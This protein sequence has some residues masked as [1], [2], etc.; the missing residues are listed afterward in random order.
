MIM[1]KCIWSPVG[2][3]VGPL[4]MNTFINDQAL[5]GMEDALAR[6]PN[7]NHLTCW[8]KELTQ[9]DRIH[10]LIMSYVVRNESYAVVRPDATVTIVRDNTIDDKF[11][12]KALP[13]EQYIRINDLHVGE[14][15]LPA[16][17]FAAWASEATWCGA[18]DCYS[19]Q[20]AIEREKA[21]NYAAEY[22]IG[23]IAWLPLLGSVVFAHPMHGL[24][25]E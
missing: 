6:A 25:D 2:H 13:G 16:N 24:E 12:L 20:P 18:D 9:Y 5:S 4:P 21:R 22:L 8:A 15:L 17:D 7:P 23:S 1:D 11:Y 19:M 10:K 3:L 14:T